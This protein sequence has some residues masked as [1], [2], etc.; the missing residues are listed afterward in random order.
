[1]WENASLRRERNRKRVIFL[2]GKGFTPLSNTHFM[3]G[4]KVY[5]LSAAD[6]E[7]LERIER[8]GLFVVRPEP[9]HA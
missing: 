1:M 2:L 3:K 7:Q 4:G 5:D 6:L 8:E 9:A